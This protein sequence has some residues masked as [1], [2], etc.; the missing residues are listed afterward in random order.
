MIKTN[1]KGKELQKDT[2]E[3]KALVAY[4]KVFK[5]KERKNQKRK[6]RRPCGFGLAL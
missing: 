1:L 5:K 4:L 2:E 6:Q 3:M